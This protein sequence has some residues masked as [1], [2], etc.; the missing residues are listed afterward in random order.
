MSLLDEA[1]FAVKGV[2]NFKASLCTDNNRDRLEITVQVA[3]KVPGNIT[4]LIE[5]ALFSI[6]VIINNIRKGK[7]I[8]APIGVEPLKELWLH[9]RGL[10]GIS[11]I[12]N[13][14][15][16]GLT[17]RLLFEQ[18]VRRRAQCALV[19]IL[20]QTLVKDLIVRFPRIK[21]Q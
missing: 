14:S 20:A 7:L 18:M 13:K 15:T 16:R 4:A 19:V 1:W 10:S 2:T 21:P 17:E 6:P 3:G 12:R 11:V 8:L 9:K 5:Q